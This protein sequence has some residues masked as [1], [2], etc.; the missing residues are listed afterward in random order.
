MKVKLNFTV[1]ID[2]QLWAEEYD[3]ELSEVRDDVRLYIEGST[4]EHLYRFEIES[5]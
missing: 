2:P 3:I 1:E 5:E 4:R